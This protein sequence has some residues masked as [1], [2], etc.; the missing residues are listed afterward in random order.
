MID[1]TISHYKILEKLGEGGMGEVYLAED[2]KLKRNVAIKILPL[3]LTKDKESRERFER[4]AQA[5]AAL[6]H[7][8]I[9]TVHEIGEFEEQVFIV[10]EY[11]EGE[12]LQEILHKN[13]QLSL[14][15]YINI[16]SQICEGLEKAHQ[17]GIVHRDIKPANIIIDKDNR[18]K[19]LDFGLAKL[20][21]VSQL[22]KETSTIG[23]IHYMSPEQ[24]RG[25]GV[26]FRSDIWSVGVI[27]YEMFTGKL[28]FKGD[29]EQAVMYSITN[30]EPE[31]LSDFRTDVP[32]ELEQYVNKCLAKDTTERYPSI[33][34]LLVDLKRLKKETGKISTESNKEIKSTEKS[35]EKVTNPDEK[36]KTTT[37]T[38]T[39]QRKKL[40]TLMAATLGILTL[41]II[42]FI[43]IRGNHTIDTLAILPFENVG[44]DENTKYLSE[45]IPESIISSLQ[46]IP[47]LN[48]T[49]FNAVL[50]RFKNETPEASDVRDEFN[51]DAVVM[52]RISLHGEDLSVSI[53]IVETRNNH[54]LAAGNFL[55]KI[56]SLV[57]IQ[58]RIAKEITDKL[59]IELSTEEKNRVFSLDS[60]N[61]EAYEKYIMGRYHW[62]QRTVYGFNQA[63]E[64]FKQ[65]I[66]IDPEYAL[67]YSGLA[68]CYILSS[69]YFLGIP[70]Y[71]NK[72]K[73][74]A[75]KALQYGPDLAESHT[76]RGYVYYWEGDIEKGRSEFAKAFELN[77]DY[78][79]A[80]YWYGEMLSR[81][82]GRHEEGIER[83]K[84]ALELDPYSVVTNAILA[85]QYK[86]AGRYL[87]AAQSY[88]KAIALDPNWAMPLQILGG[89][90]LM[91]NEFEKAAEL[92]QNFRGEEDG[93][94]KIILALTYMTM[95]EHEKAIEILEKF[96]SDEDQIIDYT[97]YSWARFIIGLSNL[98]KHD[99][100]KAI[101]EFRKVRT[102][103]PDFYN[104]NGSIALTYHLMGQ[105]RTS[106]EIYVQNART[107]GDPF[108]DEIFNKTFKDG[109]YNAETFCEFF[110]NFLKKAIEVN[111]PILGQPDPMNFIYLHA[112]EYDKFFVELEKSM[113]YEKQVRGP[114]VLLL[115]FYD[116]V[117]NDPRFVELWKKYGVNKYYK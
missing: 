64:Y 76:S 1:K 18:V 29:Y 93:Y 91:T 65:A 6:N 80:H 75:E 4:E 82:E 84:K 78:P 10:M 98:I 73:E 42:A 109:I 2:T 30:N 58:P 68:D 46:K 71:L 92:L 81:F 101:E 56:V 85:Y 63:I 113:F 61:S 9:V 47:N 66:N 14:D 34:G 52:G 5:A 35:T 62:R 53:E 51:V 96:K 110:K 11:V 45:G 117:R 40:L 79:T 107:M 19:I 26:D 108:I 31:Q 7:P 77:P 104:A 89:I 54:I 20:K 21:G 44:G 69:D 111:H 8:N 17:A 95:N 28:P 105:Y 55:E 49:S 97:S 72:A 112:K 90:Y 100:V 50:R 38:I 23:T 116:S 106:I 57:N 103:H 12:T 87:E 94:V 15:K 115:P 86:E 22:T 59:S 41:V 37:I 102:D 70:D 48:V 74:A 88:Q 27:L 114:F 24:I 32:Y 25:E 83:I 43:L 16:S 99:Y 67:A 3:H 36:K 39:P 13:R 33:E 60:Q